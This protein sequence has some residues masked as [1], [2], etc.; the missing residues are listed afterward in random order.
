MRNIK[1]ILR[2]HRQNQSGKVV[3]L[4]LSQVTR[5]LSCRNWR[6][7]FTSNVNAHRLTLISDIKPT[8]MQT[9][10]RPRQFSLQNGAA[11]QFD[12]FFRISFQQDQFSKFVKNYQL[13]I[14]GNNSA[15]SDFTSGQFCVGTSGRFSGSVGPRLRTGRQ[16]HASKNPA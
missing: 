5:S 1:R 12:A 3:I 6:F 7:R 13:A 8:A 11:S 4:T 15:L 16:F 14:S 10:G 9:R 2:L